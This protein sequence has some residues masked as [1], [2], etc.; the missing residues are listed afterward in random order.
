MNNEFEVAVIFL[1]YGLIQNGEADTLHGLFGWCKNTA[2]RNFPWVNSA[3]AQAAGRYEEACI[4]YQ[5][6]LSSSDTVLS[7]RTREFVEDQIIMCLNENHVWND[8]KDFLLNIEKKN[9]ERINV[10]QLS[11]TSAQVEAIINHLDQSSNASKWIELCDWNVLSATAKSD[12]ISSSMLSY[13][14]LLS[15]VENTLS[16]SLVDRSSLDQAKLCLCK[17]ITGKCLQECLRSGSQEHVQN[18]TIL[19]HMCNKIE[20]TAMLESD[21]FGSLRVDK[22]VG[23]SAL[24]RILGW[25]DLIAPG[26][27]NRHQLSFFNRNAINQM[28]LDLC[29]IARKHG[30]YSM[31]RTMLNKY[32]EDEL[33]MPWSMFASNFASDNNEAIDILSSTTSR[34][35]YEGVKLLHQE[36]KTSSACQFAMNLVMCMAL[37]IS[38]S[39]IDEEPLRRWSAR[40]LLTL[41]KWVHDDPQL[42]TN[43]FN[44]N[45]R[46]LCE[47]FL[48]DQPYV[49]DRTDLSIFDS[50]IGKF[51]QLSI[52]QCP[53]LAKS[54]VA[55]G[56]W[57]FQLAPKLAKSTL[58][59]NIIRENV[60][61]ITDMNL[62]KVLHLLNQSN[63]CSDDETIALQLRCL[64][65]SPP[66]DLDPGQMQILLH[67][68]RQLQHY[69][70]S[71]PNSSSYYATAAESYFKYLHLVSGKADTD[72]NAS[73]KVSVTLRLLQLV[74]KPELGLHD[75]LY[76]G[77]SQTPTIP[78]TIIIPQ[79]F[80]RINHPEPN[81]RKLLSQLVCRIAVDSPHLII[82][83]AVVGSLQDNRMD[84][85]NISMSVNEE[86]LNN[87]NLMNDSALT[88]CFNSML[89][90]IAGSAAEMVKQVKCLV[91]ELQRVTLLWDELWLIGLTQVSKRSLC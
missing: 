39:T 29:S 41:S 70:T 11:K 15:V 74:V 58:T 22:S 5:K 77:L 73:T 86:D 3:A 80:A 61:Q 56:N 32:C 79:L 57:C 60:P 27:I 40:T 19:G 50:T 10:T 6:F 75:I 49:F 9:S 47:R 35:L 7:H 64:D 20:S 69:E 42:I 18:I 65:I 1:T 52:N 26:S 36:S 28:H 62:S 82:F 44:T 14:K 21:F 89:E 51:I 33:K 81:V 83:P 84:P 48:G 90:I 43:K 31:C 2:D 63:Y 17:V 68:W 54:W 72:H 13:H 71:Q 88:C 46:Q 4:G 38:E 55:M 53:D 37:N 25:C 78:W 87:E 34:A 45:L 23:S 12:N 91:R 67:Q 59:T 24:G 85:T 66:I 30:N 8:M 16:E 76:E